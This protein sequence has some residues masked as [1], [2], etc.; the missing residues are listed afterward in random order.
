M[1]RT[2]DGSWLAVVRTG[3]SAQSSLVMARSTDGGVTWSA[4]QEVLTGPQ[5]RIAAGK[6]PGLCL[7]PNGV[8][9][10]LTAHTKN[11]CRVYVSADGT[12]REWSEAFIITSQGG[13]NTSMICTG[14]DKLL[15]FTPANGRI[16]C[17]QVTIAKNAPA[18][19]SSLPAP[20]SITVTGAK[21]N[22]SW[23]PPADAANV[24]HYLVTPVFIRPS[25]DNKDTELYSYAPI[26]T[27]DAATQ[28]ELGRV[29]SI[30]GTYRIEVAAVDR[31][32]RVSP[33]A[34]SAELV[35]GAAAK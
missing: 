34:S 13:G 8:L 27:R 26:R 28:L 12:G 25:A 30:G 33:A 23:K 22:V 5:K 17:W 15:I 20:T 24:S 14:P 35:A 10:L 6:L 16:Q 4:V 31:D 19:K 21:V 7:L 32:G 3:S 9:V 11:H 1:A 29:L 18:A 2:S